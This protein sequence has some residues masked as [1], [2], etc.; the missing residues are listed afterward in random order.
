MRF[1]SRMPYAFAR[2]RFGAVGLF[3]NGVYPGVIGDLKQITRDTFDV[4]DTEYRQGRNPLTV[5]ARMNRTH[6]RYSGRAYCPP[7]RG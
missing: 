6:S 3:E 7:S 5:N 2:E 1:A 4:V